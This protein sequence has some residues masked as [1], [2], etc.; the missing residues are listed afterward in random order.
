MALALDGIKIMNMCWIGPGAFC[1]E[2]L[3]DNGHRAMLEHCVASVKFICDRGVTH[4]LV[5]HRIASFAQESTRYCNYTKEKFGR[6]ITVIR[7]SGIP[8][9][10]AEQLLADPEHYRA[11]NE[12]EAQWGRACR[13]AERCYFQLIDAG[14]KPQKRRKCF[15]VPNCQ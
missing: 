15:E 3:S 13:E 6:E 7:P 5:R 11:K 4:E 1:T 2:M 10:T 12:A 8:H 14:Q 9:V